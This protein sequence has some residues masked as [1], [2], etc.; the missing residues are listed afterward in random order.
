M[1][2]DDILFGSDASSEVARG[3]GGVLVDLLFDNNSAYVSPNYFGG[4]WGISETFKSSADVNL[5]DGTTVLA[6][7]ATTHVLVGQGTISAGVAAFQ[8]ATSDDVYLVVR[9]SG[10]ETVCTHDITPV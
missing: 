5:P 4:Y 3:N 2:F 1:A 6:Y 8:V 9:P 7:H 10:L